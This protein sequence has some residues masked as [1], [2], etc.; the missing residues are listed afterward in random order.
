MITGRQ[1]RAARALL[2][3]TQEMLAEKALVAL[4]AL[5]RL[6]SE[7]LHPRPSGANNPP[8]RRRESRL[9]DGQRPFVSGEVNSVKNTPKP[10]PTLASVGRAASAASCRI[11]DRLRPGSLARLV[12]SAA[13]L[14]HRFPNRYT[15]RRDRLA[16]GARSVPVQGRLLLGRTR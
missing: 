13:A 10:A 1:V 14:P 2:N 9:D 4:T 6:E 7:P 12:A 11:A 5:K 15:C 8:H 16:A 3:W